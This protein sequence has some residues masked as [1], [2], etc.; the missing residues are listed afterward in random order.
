MISRQCPQDEVDVDMQEIEV[1]EMNGVATTALSSAS[2]SAL[3]PPAMRSPRRE[4]HAAEAKQ[5]FLALLSQETTLHS[6]TSRQ[7]RVICTPITASCQGSTSTLHHNPPI[8]NSDRTKMCSWY[9]EMSTFLKISPGTASRAMSYLDRFMGSGS[10]HAATASRLRDEYQLVALTA[11]F[12]AIKLYERLNIM[13]CHVSYLSRGRYT[14]EEVIAMEMA[15]LKGLKWKVTSST[16][17]DYADLILYCIRPKLSVKSNDVALMGLRDL[18][19]LQIQLSDFYTLYSTKK[20]SMV[21][22]AALMNAY[23]VKK[24]KFVDCDRDVFLATFRELISYYDRDDVYNIM[25]NLC[26]LVD[27]SA[28]R[29]ISTEFRKREENK[30][31]SPMPSPAIDT[32]CEETSLETFDAALETMEDMNFDTIMSHF[33]CCGSIPISNTDSAMESNA[34]Q[35]KPKHVSSNNS[36]GIIG[37]NNSFDTHGSIKMKTPKGESTKQSPVSIATMLFGTGA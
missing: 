25:D 22:L 37:N 4:D 7:A 12:I 35:V 23:E 2:F 29:R 10:P 1:I 36:P 8:N 14:S 31:P 6:V 26:C 32:T 33:L 15:M 16:K 20:Q 11:L 17:L 28:E 30:D 21:A 24:S 13:P 27:P 9:Y 5:V 3:S 19:S 18:M 34:T